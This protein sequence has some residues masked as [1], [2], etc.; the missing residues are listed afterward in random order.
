MYNIP[1]LTSVSTNDVNQGNPFAWSIE[2]RAIPR[3][4]NEES[5]VALIDPFSPENILSREFGELHYSNLDFSNAFPIA[6]TLRG[7]NIEVIGP[8]SARWWVRGTSKGSNKEVFPSKY[9]TSEFY[10]M[11]DKA[12]FDVIIGIQ[13][14]MSHCLL[15]PNA[16]LPYIATHHR[17]YI[18]G[19]PSIRSKSYPSLAIINSQYVAEDSTQDEQAAVDAKRLQDSQDMKRKEAEKVPVCYSFAL[20]HW[21]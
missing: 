18:S 13:D 19:L 20:I 9:L 8:Y 2:Y 14:I 12:N 6:Q 1:A 16:P 17:W 11:K 21:Y 15:I 7:G 3:R 4:G 10:I 5:G